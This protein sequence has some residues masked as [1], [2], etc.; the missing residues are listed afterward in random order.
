MRG[1]TTANWRL[2]EMIN[3]SLAGIELSL[4]RLTGNNERKTVFK[5][6]AEQTSR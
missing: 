1:I 2:N 4:Q 6:A 5:L 3:C